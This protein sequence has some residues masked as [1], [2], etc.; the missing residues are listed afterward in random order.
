MD[1]KKIC[2]NELLA[3]YFSLLTEGGKNVAYATMND[4]TT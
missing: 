2:A 4:L 1:R 3:P